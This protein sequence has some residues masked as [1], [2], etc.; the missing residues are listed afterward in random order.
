M[1]LA[2]AREIAE[3]QGLR[4]LSAQRI[5]KS[6][7]YS[8]GTLYNHFESLDDLILHLNGRTLDDLYEALRNVPLPDEPEAALLTLAS[9]YIE[10][11]AKR[12]KLWS[13]LFE[14]HL[15]DGQ[16]LPQWHTDKILKLLGLMERALRPLF[17]ED[18]QEARLHAARVLW[19]SVHGMVSLETGDKLAKAESV[20]E[21][22]A[23]LVTNF[24]TGLRVRRAP[25]IK[26]IGEA[27]KR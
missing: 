18:E 17:R 25:S 5:T 9:A 2:A 27:L 8:V 21:M 14:H 10:F 12:P 13:L 19:S 23:T 1:M 3:A 22:V 16:E 7:G 26:E 6:F 4:G 15:P 24:V 11:T 20:E